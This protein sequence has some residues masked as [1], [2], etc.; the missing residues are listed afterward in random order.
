MVQVSVERMLTCNPKHCCG[1][2]A[3]MSDCVA[4]GHNPT[5][6]PEKY[7]GQRRYQEIPEHGLLLVE[8]DASEFAGPT[9]M[10]RV[11]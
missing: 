10:A 11:R 3:G 9:Q 2:V 8:Q 7:M 4:G 6:Q 5:F 1:P